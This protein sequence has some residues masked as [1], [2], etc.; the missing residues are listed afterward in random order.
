[1]RMSS[2]VSL[3]SI[4]SIVTKAVSLRPPASVAA[5]FEGELPPILEVE[6]RALGHD[7]LAAC[8]IQDKACFAVVSGQREAQGALARYRG[9]DRWPVR[10]RRTCRAPRFREAAKDTG[11]ARGASLA[12]A[13]SDGDGLF[14]RES[15]PESVTRTRN[16]W[17]GLGLVVRGVRPR[18]A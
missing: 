18:A 10:G 12:S 17:A 8:R 1:M 9:P 15:P 13:T 14:L 7:D 3:R 4:R 6:D 16:W 11:S 2:G 5:I